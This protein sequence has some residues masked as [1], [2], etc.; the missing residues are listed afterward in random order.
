MF[1]ATACPGPYLKSKFPYIEEEVNRRLGAEPGPT[2]PPTPTPEPGTYIEYT[3]QKGDTLNKIAA[4][5]NTTVDAILAINPQ[6]TNPNKIY[7]GQVIKIP[8][9]TPT[10]EPTPQPEPT[11]EPE[12]TPASKY[13]PVPFLVQVLIDNLNYRATP[14]GT[15]KGQ[16]G[17]GTF[18]I[19]EV[20]DDW[21]RL[22]SGVGWIYLANPSYVK[23]LDSTNTI[24]KSSSFNPY[25]IRVTATQLNIR[26]NASLTSKI[27]G[28]LNK[29]DNVTIVEEKD[30]WGKLENNKGWICLSWTRKI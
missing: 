21:G 24:Q 16:T 22:K 25:K 27:V 6:I 9:S 7:P 3:V 15:I 11:P 19:V 10:P 18:T 12:P 4:E 5:Y 28:T 8:V 26:K 23:I 14:A 20:K 2:P 1:Q 30:G 29:G 13:P 17:K